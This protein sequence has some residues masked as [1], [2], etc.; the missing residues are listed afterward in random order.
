MKKNLVIL[1]IVFIATFLCV[2][3]VSAASTGSNVSLQKKISGAT[4]HQTVGITIKDTGK[5]Y[6]I[7]NGKKYWY[8]Y[9]TYYSSSI[10]V[11]S[12][13]ITSWGTG[14][15]LQ[16]K[17]NHLHDQSW[18]KLGYGTFW[19]KSTTGTTKLSKKYNKYTTSTWLKILHTYNTKTLKQWF[20]TTKNK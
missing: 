15:Y 1:T 3:A 13:Y 4:S 14:G 7:N 8:K 11:Y 2:G 5:I 18:Y 12:K 6:F 17:K 9:T 20:E 19:G 10:N 16:Y